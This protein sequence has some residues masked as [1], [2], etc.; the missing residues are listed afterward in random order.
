MALL[1]M[2]LGWLV[3]DTPAIDMSGSSEC[4]KT[5]IA[6]GLRDT[7]TRENVNDQLREFIDKTDHHHIQD[8]R[9]KSKSVAIIICKD[10]SGCSYIAKKYNKKDLLGKSVFLTMFNETD[11]EN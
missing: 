11:T 5:V 4:N 2:E 6:S 1:F 9:F 8:I 3:H 7:I 10:W